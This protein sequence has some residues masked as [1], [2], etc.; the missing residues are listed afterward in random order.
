MQA[1]SGGTLKSLRRANSERLLALLL[2]RGP[3]H[4]A[5]LARQAELSRTT[6]S[7]IIAELMDRGVVIEAESWPA[8]LDGRAKETL[9]V[10]PDA[11]LILGMDFTFDRVWMHMT[12]LDGNEIASEGARV[13]I[14]LGWN[15]RIDVATAL[16]D[17]IIDE[18]GLDRRRI[19]GAGIGVPAPVDKATGHIEVALPG[20]PWSMVNAV[21]EFSRRFDLRLY[22]ENST[23][24]EAVAEAHFGAGQHI[25]NL[26]YVALSNGIGSGLIIGG[27]VQSGAAGM[28][29]ELG[30]VSVDIDGPVCV[31][32]NRGCLV[33]YAGIPAVLTSLRAQIGDSGTIADVLER[34]AAGDRACAGVLADAGQVTGRL[35]AGICNLL[36]PQRIVVGGELSGAGEVLLAPMRDAIRRY[37]LTPIRE[38][39]LLPAALD[40]GVR[41]G[42]VGGTALVHGDTAALASM[43]VG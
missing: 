6:V 17:R 32:G 22:I 41:A 30:H 38:V 11:G 13:P 1:T 26:L 18:R 34:C 20:Q 24:L 8:D 36:N 39:E 23:R 28:A 5:E 40:L 27:R 3:L 29:G 10:N 12:R 21:E 7:T 14:G 42:A 35:L 43:L 37:A 16:L 9:V 33:L 25:E 4:R 15:D 2:T 31:C 19:L